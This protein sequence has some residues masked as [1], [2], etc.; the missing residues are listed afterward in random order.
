MKKTTGDFIN[1][2]PT[3]AMGYH[4]ELTSLRIQH[5]L[6]TGEYMPREDMRH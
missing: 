2:S 6:V 4:L 5:E 1:I 3:N